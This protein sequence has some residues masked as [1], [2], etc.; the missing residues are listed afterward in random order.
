MTEKVLPIVVLISGNGSNL[1][2]IIDAIASKSLPIKICAVISDRADAF[3]LQRA[4]QA[5]IPTLVLSAKNYASRIDYDA[6]LQ[7]AIDAYQAKLIVLAGFMRILST[8][9]VQHYHGR[10]INIHPSLLPKYKG[11][12]THARVLEAG[13][14]LHGCT[15][16]F[17][18]DELDSGAI[19]GQLE[20]T[21]EANDSIESLTAKV[22]QLEH[23]LYP[24]VIQ[25]FAEGKI[26][27]EACA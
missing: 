13:D 24:A 18:S 16:H 10:L 17:V 6:A 15:V 8:N 9:F 22:H 21:V 2:A 4:A 14:Q 27:S 5:N 11:L 7:A 12:N 25:A 26:K 20:C 23:Q 19:L 1:Q 3:G